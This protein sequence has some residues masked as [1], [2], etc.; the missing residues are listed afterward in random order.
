MHFVFNLGIAISYCLIPLCLFS[1]VIKG[2]RYLT[3]FFRATVIKFGGFIL[4]CAIGHVLEA[5][6]LYSISQYWH[7]ITFAVS[8]LV[9]LQMPSISTYAIRFIKQTARLNQELKESEERF[10]AFL[11]C[12]RLV[13]WIKD[14]DYKNIWGNRTMMERFGPHAIGVRDDEWLPAEVAH[15]TLANDRLVLETGLPHEVVETVPTADG[16]KRFWLSYKFL[17]QLKQ[18]RYIGGVAIEITERERLRREVETT[19]AELEQFAYAAS[20]DLKTPIRGISGLLSVLADSLTTRLTQ[21]ERSILDQIQTD[22]QYATE[23][24]DG[25]LTYSR[26]GRLQSRLG[27]VDIDEVLCRVCERLSGLLEPCRAI[28]NW[29]EMPS[30]VADP[31]QMIQAFENLIENSIKY[32]G[33]QDPIINVG[34]NV[35]DQEWIFWVQDNG[36][37]VPPEYQDH[38]F[39]MFRRLHSR[40]EIEGTGIGLA[41]VRKIA[42]RHNGR[43]WLESQGAGYGATVY[44]SISRHLHEES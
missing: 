20:H 14:A 44:F 6:R 10:Q 17:L 37:G 36:I 12:P 1:V 8:V 22:C 3:P 11:D 9:A 13:A 24:V 43:A 32:R 25:I 40:A 38:L 26:I 21:H 7:G 41:T 27:I 16:I 29:D 18:Q 23:L 5:F 34:V 39:I 28:L 31:T 2:W 19:N 30:V 15:E 42:Q 33:Q 35:T 4:V